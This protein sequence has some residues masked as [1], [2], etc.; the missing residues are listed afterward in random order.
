VVTGI[1]PTTSG[2]LDQRRIRPDNQAPGGSRTGTSY[3]PK[4]Q[5]FA[6]CVTTSGKNFYY[7]KNDFSNS[8]GIYERLMAGWVCNEANRRKRRSLPLKKDEV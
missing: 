6:R 4:N 1:E 3:F 5:R 2:L 8:F 7:I